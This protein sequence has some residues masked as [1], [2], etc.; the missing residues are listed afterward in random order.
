MQIKIDEKYPDDYNRTIMLSDETTRQKNQIL[1]K[2]KF[3]KD[4]QAK[5]PEFIRKQREDLLTQRKKDQA[6][7]AA[8]K[9][10][11][12]EAEKKK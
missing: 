10:K 8:L 3:Y 1:R 5:M 9:E 11:E 2:I 6:E 7:A 4:K 12:A